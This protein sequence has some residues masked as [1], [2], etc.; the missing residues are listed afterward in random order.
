MRLH[1]KQV[2]KNMENISNTKVFNTVLLK[3]ETP[4]IHQ[5]LLKGVILALQ[6]KYK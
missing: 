3:N 2:N 6:K 5:L 1:L 4:G